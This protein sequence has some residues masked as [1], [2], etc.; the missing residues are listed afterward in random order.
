[1]AAGERGGHEGTGLIRALP[2]AGRVN[3][4]LVT[5]YDIRASVSLTD[6]TGARVKLRRMETAI[7]GTRTKARASA[8]RVCKLRP[9]MQ[10]RLARA[11]L[12]PTPVISDRVARV[13]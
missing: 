4:R 12:S 11:R 3:A 13:K 5:R 9:L 1:M 7:R 6:I 2:V 8:S 10:S